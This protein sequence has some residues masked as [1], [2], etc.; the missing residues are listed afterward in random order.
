MLNRNKKLTV[1][2][3][4]G[5]FQRVKAQ[6]VCSSISIFLVA[7]SCKKAVKA[8][9][10]SDA[11]VF[12]VSNTHSLQIWKVSLKSLGCSITAGSYSWH[13][14]WV[15]WIPTV[16]QFNHSF[17]THHRKSMKMSIKKIVH[18][19]W[20]IIHFSILS[21]CVLIIFRKLFWLNTLPLFQS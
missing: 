11:T 13:S 17:I 6:T 18:N 4:G 5:A 16:S 20:S 12:W 1:S 7:E 9:S 8:K 14:G 2:L 10:W 19:S 3:G 21:I 15:Q